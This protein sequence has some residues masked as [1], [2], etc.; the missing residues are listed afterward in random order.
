GVIHLLDAE[1]DWMGTAPPENRGNFFAGPDTI[2][3]LGRL[4]G[5]VWRII[6]YLRPDDA[7][8]G[9]EF[10]ASTMQSVLDEHPYLGARVCNVQ[11]QSVYRVSNRMVDQLRFGRVFLAGD[12]AH[13]HSP[14]GGQG[15]NTG[16]QD[17][18]NLA[19][20]LAARVKGVAPEA[21]LDTYQTERLPVIAAVLKETSLGHHLLSAYGR[22]L[23]K[24][25]WA[26]TAR[27]L[28]PSV[29]A[30][31]SRTRLQQ[32]VARGLGQ[33]AVNYRSSSM[34]RDDGARVGRLRAGDRAPDATLLGATGVQ[35]RLH[36]VL[37]GDTAHHLLA[38]AG[39]HATDAEIVTLGMRLTDWRADH[40]SLVVHRVLRRG[41]GYRPI[42]PH[43]DDLCDIEGNVHARY[44]SDTA[45]F[46]IV[47]P[48]G[49]LAAR[50]T[51]LT[52]ETLSDILTRSG[53]SG[54]SALRTSS[55]GL[56]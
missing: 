22:S 9:G 40:A 48:D 35:T 53:G 15:L 46:Q 34:V 42:N 36:Q 18:H 5:R 30:A 10:T 29:N 44:S 7:R 56:H 32:R 49:Y 28:A 52:P 1:L 21:L 20:K 14:M 55:A 3:G 8:A 26:A 41:P 24:P 12:A 31:I 43:P 38:F 23:A 11:W 13:I 39:V 45:R 54:P 16:V 51:N 33:L 2:V 17:A 6:G 27:V 37:A 50:L 19:W 4:D 47:R 25:W